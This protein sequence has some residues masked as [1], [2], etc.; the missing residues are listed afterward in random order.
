MVS[1]RSRG[2]VST[3]TDSEVSMKVCMTCRRVNLD[4]EPVCLECG[5]KEFNHI[6]LE[7]EIEESGTGE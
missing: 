7:E 2:M 5:G 6:L 4:D 1:G 3:Q